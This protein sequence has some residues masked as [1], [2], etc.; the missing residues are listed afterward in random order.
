[1]LCGAHG[2]STRCS[3]NAVIVVYGEAAKRIPAE[4]LTERDQSLASSRSDL[5]SR[6]HGSHR[7]AMGARQ[8]LK[9]VN[10]P[11]DGGADMDIEPSYEVSGSP[12]AHTGRRRARGGGRL[13]AQ[14]FPPEVG[15]GMHEGGILEHGALLCFGRLR[16]S[17]T[18]EA[19]EA[20]HHA[21]LTLRLTV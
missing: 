16:R 20:A 8:R 17:F 21:H 6:P 15:D 11:A 13:R 12:P 4:A 3:A 5:R 14:G 7:G 1:M 19:A 9:L 2:L 10:N 18:L